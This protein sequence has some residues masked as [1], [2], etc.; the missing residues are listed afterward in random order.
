MSS[1]KIREAFNSGETLIFGHRGAMA[2]APMNT[3]A[4]FELARA[5]GAD[6]IEL[7]LRLSRDRSSCRY[8]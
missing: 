3:L 2:H 8:T 6:G 7:D 1:R 4:A 5:Q